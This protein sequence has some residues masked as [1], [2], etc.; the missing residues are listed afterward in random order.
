M[1]SMNK[2]LNIASKSGISI[3]LLFIMSVLLSSCSSTTYLSSWKDPKF[4]GK[5]KKVMVVAL[6]KD[7]DY[8]K[9]YEYRI[10]ALLERSKVGVEASIDIFGVESMPTEDDLIRELEKGSFDGLLA[11]KYTG[12]K[13]YTSVYPYYNSFPGWYRGGYDYMYS[14][15][16]IE[17]HRLANTEAMLYTEYSK[18]A[19]WYGKMQTINAYSMYDLTN[20]LAE[21]IIEDLKI[22][23]LV[24][25][26]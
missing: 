26:K 24:S 11:V 6:V 17:T 2:K 1:K 12:S 25:G 9:S 8:R 23:G 7:F 18:G 20:S 5:L 3:L 19:V 10:A 14:P 15:G 4:S 13:T 21:R 22:N 16:Y